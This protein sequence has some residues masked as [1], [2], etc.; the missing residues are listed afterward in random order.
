MSKNKSGKNARYENEILNRP[1]I[2]EKY[3][4]QDE[5]CINIEE[6]DLET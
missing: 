4:E 1:K 6:Q 5:K 2:W 3:I